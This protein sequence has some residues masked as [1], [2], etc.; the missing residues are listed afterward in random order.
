[1]LFHF[2]HKENSYGYKKSKQLGAAP[3]LYGFGLGKAGARDCSGGWGWSD[4]DGNNN[5]TYS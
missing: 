4:H 2:W 5:R 3:V 1:M